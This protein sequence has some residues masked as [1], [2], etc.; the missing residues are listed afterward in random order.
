MECSDYFVTL[1]DFE[2]IGKILLWAL[3]TIRIIKKTPGL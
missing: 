1:A 2:K 3:F